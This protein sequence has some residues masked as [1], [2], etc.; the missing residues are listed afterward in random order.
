MAR[1]THRLLHT[2][3]GNS[4]LRYTHKVKALAPIAYWPLADSGGSVATDA[5]GNGRD[6]AYTSTTLGVTGIGDGRTAATFDG[7]SS[8]VNMYSALLSAVYPG[9]PMTVAVWAKVSGSG[10]WTDGT[11]RRVLRIT[12]ASNSNALTIRRNATNNLLEIKMFTGVANATQPAITLNNTVNT[13]ITTAWFHLAAT[14]TAGGNLQAY[15]NGAAFG[16]PAAID[17]VASGLQSTTTTIGSS[18]TGPADVWSGSI[19]HVCLFNRVLPAS[20]VASL[21]VI[22]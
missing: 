22:P 18:S 1:P 12:S 16:S 14:W 3:G 9:S 8:F 13:E 10:V 4:S 20:E 5:S 17:T 2:L 11:F 15:L 19:A 6:G 21:A 7:T